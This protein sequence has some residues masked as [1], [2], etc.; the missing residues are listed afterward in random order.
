MKTEIV[1]QT[2]RTYTHTHIKLIETNFDGTKMI[3]VFE[4][5]KKIQNEKTPETKTGM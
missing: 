5:K 1:V 4:M 2:T 3:S